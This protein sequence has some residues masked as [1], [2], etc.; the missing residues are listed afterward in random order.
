MPAETGI[1]PHRANPIALPLWL[2]FI[3]V[4]GFGSYLV[5]REKENR[6]IARGEL[7][8]EEQREILDRKELEQQVDRFLRGEIDAIPPRRR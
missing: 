6:R 2:I 8:W 7:T 3:A 4:V 5:W 1:S